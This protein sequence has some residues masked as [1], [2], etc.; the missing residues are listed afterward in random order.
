MTAHQGIATLRPAQ[1]IED[2]QI[3]EEHCPWCD[4]PIPYEKYEEIHGRIQA[5]ERKRA[6]E[7][8]RRL[9]EQV[10]I[11][12]T[13]AEAK[14]RAEI[15][16]ARKEGAL[17]VEKAKQ[18]AAIREAAAREEARKA[19]EAASAAKIAEAEQA[20]KVA[21]RQAKEQRDTLEKTMQEAATR[22]AAVREEAR[23]AAEAASAAK[24]A[25]AEQAKKVA[26]QQAKEQR[27]ALEKT[28][29]E[30][31]A[32]E[33][34]AR[35]EARKAAEAISAAKIAEAEQAKKVAEQHAKDQGEALE[36]TKLEAAAKE[37]VA[38]EESRKTVEAALGPR[39]AEAEHAKKVAEEQLQIA[40]TDQENVLNQRLKEQRDALEKANAEAVNAERAKAFNE[41]LKVEGKLQ[42]VTRQLQQKSAE[43]LGEGAE[44]DLFETLKSEFPDDKIC[45]VDKG[46]PGADIIHNVVHNG[47]ICGCIVYDSKNRNAWRWDY[48]TKLRDDQ[49]RANGDHAILS[50]LVLPA[51]ARQIHVH[52]GVLIANPARVIALVEILRKHIVQIHGLRLGN[53]ARDQKTTQLYEFIMSDRA[54]QLLGQIETQTDDMLD[55]EVKEKKAHDATWKKRGEL[56]RSVQ[57]A[58]AD[59]TSEI[60]RIIGTATDEQ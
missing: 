24:I 4:Q 41:K 22:E 21:E 23:K 17:A 32:R 26:E 43:E 20:T 53:E 35:E 45:R 40:K 48:V 55:L 42:E 50:T 8:E 39:I 29:Q 58:R 37:A 59:F 5:E 54:A 27:E 12:K 7:L 1:Q 51:G 31:A 19:A 28:K 14:A 38:R 36:K 2:L 6:L 34:V 52:D 13:Q 10:A 60:E 30:A 15:E 18:E 16:H 47:K 57:R 49:L 33:A 56:I 46:A 25:E 9:N 11:E 44:V 3:G